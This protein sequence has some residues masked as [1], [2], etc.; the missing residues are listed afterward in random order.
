MV[1]EVVLAELLAADAA[2]AGDSVG[3][4]RT[5]VYPPGIRDHVFG[6]SDGVY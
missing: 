1:V 6:H 2:A 3:S 4:V 5:L